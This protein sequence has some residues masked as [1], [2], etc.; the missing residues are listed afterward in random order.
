M[1][2]IHARQGDIIV[3]IRYLYDRSKRVRSHG[4][5]GG[6]EGSAWGRVTCPGQL[7]SGLGR[8]E[9]RHMTPKL[10]RLIG[11]RGMAMGG[12]VTAKELQRHIDCNTSCHFHSCTTSHQLTT[13]S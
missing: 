8:V 1:C 12:V 13:L 9:S 2:A 3:P 7:P 4:G 11:G 6:G 10:S 5:E